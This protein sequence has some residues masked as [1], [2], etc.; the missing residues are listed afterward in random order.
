MSKSLVAIL[1]YN[2]VHYTDTL[3]EMLKPYERNDYDLAVIDNGSEPTKTSKYTTWRSEEN[4]Y[5]GGGLDMSI[6]MFIESPEYDSFVLLNSDMIVHGYNFIKS[7]R[8]ALF[9][10]EDLMI[11][12]PCV[13]QPEKN[14]CFWKQCHCWNSKEIRFVP[15][16]DYQCALM[17]REFAEKVQGFGSKYGWVQDLMTGIICEDNNWKIGVCDWI[18]IVHI[19]NGTVK[20]TPTLSNYNILAQQEM[21]N[22]F[23]S[24]GLVDRVNSLKSK[25]IG[26]GRN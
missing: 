26:Y 7:L 1:H 19:G 23:T 11:A 2:T 22:Y 25:S 13:I 21:D 24:K 15:F 5:Y 18:P 10:R 12:S 8:D 14:Q 17:K 20:E 4:V 3:Y 9:S 6:Q 16:V